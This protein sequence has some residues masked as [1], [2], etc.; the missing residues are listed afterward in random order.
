MRFAVLFVFLAGCGPAVLSTELTPGV[1]VPVDGCPFQ[2]T[3]PNETTAPIHD[4]GRVGP[5]PHVRAQHLAFRGDPA[6]SITVVWETDFDT[7]ASA[8]TLDGK[9]YPGFSYAYPT[10]SAGIDP[11]SVRV[12]EVSVCGLSPGSMHSYSV[13]NGGVDGSFS[14]APAPGS[15]SQKLLV[16][17]DSRDSFPT[18]GQL[19][20]AG[21]T[22]GVDGMIF[23]GD[24]VLLGIQQDLWDGWFSA[25]APVLP[26]LPMAFALG[27]HEAN[28][29]HVFAQFPGP[30]NQQWYSYDW[31]DLH[32]VVLNDS[33]NPMSTITNEQK[34]FLDT[35][36]G[37]ST[38]LFKVVVHH[39]PVYT[40]Y[41]GPDITGH[42]HETLLEQNWV[43]LYDQHHVDVV[44]NGHVHGFERTWPLQAGTPVA[45]GQG[46][47]YTTFGGA[48]ATMVPLVP[49]TF[50]AQQSMSYGYQ[51]V[52]VAGRTLTLTA[53]SID[54]SVLDSYSITK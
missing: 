54:G 53:K 43:P 10:D 44:F 21:Q 26:S 17:G 31:G 14:T 45:D 13:P 35:D 5:T 28:A 37:A 11:P 12:H 23:T 16:L 18:F 41:E 32:V 9:V 34:T 33:A 15:A 4:D 3:T 7:T 30:A 19:L 50:I 1:E 25:A 52:E 6:T 24:A 27:N 51:L 38:R 49:E 8:I 46:T 20:Q 40:S 47:V 2:V 36:L 48:G 29:R 22:D 42:M 39:K